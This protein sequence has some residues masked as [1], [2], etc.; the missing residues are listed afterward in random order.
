MKII[1]LVIIVCIVSI[2]LFAQDMQYKIKK[3]AKTFRILNKDTSVVNFMKASI[4]ER[5]GKQKDDI[6]YVDIANGFSYKFPTFFYDYSYICQ[7]YIV[8]IPKT[9]EEEQSFLASKYNLKKTAQMDSLYKE[10][11]LKYIQKKQ[12]YTYVC[13]YFSN[14]NLGTYG[15][16]D[17][18]YYEDCLY[19]YYPRED[20]LLR[21]KI[22]VMNSNDSWSYLGTF[23]KSPNADSV[24]DRVRND[25][26][27]YKN[28]IYSIAAYFIAR[29]KS[30]NELFDK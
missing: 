23:K 25:N 29:K 24:I 7:A 5:K 19:F 11:Y 6:A 13:F 26:M 15:C 9:F 4:S 3:P 22:F 28:D 14:E 17:V 21:V 2:H 27:A 8:A 10:F 12:D 1:S 18:D 30:I 16:E 20:N